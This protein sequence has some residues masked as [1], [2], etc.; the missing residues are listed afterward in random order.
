MSRLNV[1]GRRREG[2][3]LVALNID[4]PG[5]DGLFGLQ[6]IQTKGYVGATGGKDKLLDLIGFDVE[7]IYDSTLRFWLINQRPP[8][9]KNK[10]YINAL[11]IGINA[12]VEVFEFKRGKKKMKHIRTVV[13]PAIFSPNGIAIMDGG[14]FVISNDHSGKGEY[15]SA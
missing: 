8:V 6:T 2:S 7:V 14:A 4:T 5:A 1:S 9:D 11:K 15:L 10:K 12:T 13:D 3:E